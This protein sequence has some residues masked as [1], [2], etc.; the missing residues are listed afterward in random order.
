MHYAIGDIVVYRPGYDS[1]L[2]RVRITNRDPDIK[3]GRPGFD[4]EM[5][6]DSL[7][8]DEV[9]LVIGGVW[10]YDE[11]IVEVEPGGVVALALFADVERDPRLN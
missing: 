7:R 1:E 3:N 10:G 2:R 6:D 5:L 9:D 11:Q 8:I 4:G